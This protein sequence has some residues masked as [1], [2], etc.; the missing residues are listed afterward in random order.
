MDSDVD[1]VQR[2][3]IVATLSDKALVLADDAHVLEVT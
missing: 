2:L 1:F 3:H